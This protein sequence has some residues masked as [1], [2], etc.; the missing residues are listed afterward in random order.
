MASDKPCVLC[1]SKTTG[2]LA[3]QEDTTTTCEREAELK[4]IGNG[5]GCFPEHSMASSVVEHNNLRHTRKRGDV[6]AVSDVLLCGTLAS[7]ANSQG[8]SS[9]G[10]VAASHTG[11]DRWTH[12]A[13]YGHDH[14]SRKLSVFCYLAS[15]CALEAATC[16]SRRTRYFSRLLAVCLSHR[17]ETFS[18]FCRPSSCCV[19]LHTPGLEH[20]AGC[21][22]SW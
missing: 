1:P 7:V 22:H 18:R 2:P 9:R 14:F 10:K 6:V 11:T 15:D 17:S 3:R 8:L 21:R 13:N 19:G 5:T 12:Q 16:A 20:L 4:K